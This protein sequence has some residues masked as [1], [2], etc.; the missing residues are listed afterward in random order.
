[1]ASW[2]AAERLFIGRH[3]SLDMAAK[4]LTAEAFSRALAALTAL[5]G[6]GGCRVREHISSQA[7]TVTVLHAHAQAAMHW[8]QRNGTLLADVCAFTP[9][10][11]SEMDAV[12]SRHFPETTADHVETHSSSH[13]LQKK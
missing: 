5:P 13:P 3:R 4:S 8:D 10:L 6:L 1:M 7:R 11:A 9:T 2:S 12:C